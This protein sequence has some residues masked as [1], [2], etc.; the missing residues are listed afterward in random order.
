MPTEQN[1]S[2][3]LDPTHH[4]SSLNDQKDT[5]QPTCRFAHLPSLL[6]C[7]VISEAWAAAHGDTPAS[8]RLSG[9]SDEVTEKSNAAGLPC[10]QL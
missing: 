3:P 1:S 7:F 9:L 8:D 2:L 5:N 10:D 4:K 6:L